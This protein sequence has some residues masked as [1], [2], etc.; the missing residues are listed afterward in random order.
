MRSINR[1]H[2]VPFFYKYTTA[3]TAIAVLKTQT[4]RWSSPL[5][6]NDPFDVPREWTGFTPAELFEAFAARFALYLRGEAR[7]GTDAAGKWLAV[8]KPRLKENS[9]AVLLSELRVFLQLFARDRTE[10]AS[11]EF[12]A[13]WRE[14]VPGMRILCFSEDP[15]SAAM[16]AHY[17]KGHTGIVLQFETS[18]ERDSSWLLAQPV[19]YRVAKPS[20]PNAE[21]WAR[22][23]LGEI[24]LD[25]D[26]FLREY[27]FVKHQ[28]WSYEREHRV[29]SAKKP[30]ET[31]A[32]LFA[33]YVFHPA[34]LTS[35]VLGAKTEPKDE[36]IIRDLVKKHYSHARIYSVLVQ[37][38]C[39]S[40]DGGLMHRG[41]RA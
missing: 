8:M 17:A 21:T 26:E 27:Y 1:R 25:W 39:D 29:V 19:I 15:S 12:R 18:D 34:D 41:E 13:A 7:P 35:I 16:W 23:L 3:D 14:K 36:A 11:E 9:E 2:D 32:D 40:G 20:L 28:D 33:D 22:A 37:R 31:A 10:K 6:F 30:T 24:T 38:E 5:T 4:L